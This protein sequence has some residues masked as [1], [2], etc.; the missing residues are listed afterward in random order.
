[1]AKDDDIFDEKLGDGEDFLDLDMSDLSIDDVSKKP[2]TGKSDGDIIDLIEL[3]EKGDASEEKGEEDLLQ[4][5]EDDEFKLEEDVSQEPK[6]DTADDAAAKKMRRLAKTIPDADFPGGDTDENE[7]EGITTTLTDIDLSEIIDD[8]DLSFEEDDEVEE[9][10]DENAISLE[11][12][13]KTLEDMPAPKMPPPKPRESTQELSVGGDQGEPLEVDLIQPED[14]IVQEE[15]SVEDMEKIIEE[16][17]IEGIDFELDTSPEEDDSSIEPFG[18]L[19]MEESVKGIDLDFESSEGIE[20]IDS[21]LVEETVPTTLEVPEELLVPEPEPEPVLE[22]AVAAPIG[23]S[24]EKA[25]EII[26]RV[27]QDTVERVAKETISELFAQDTIERIARESMKEAAEKV[28][29]EAI[30][31]LKQSLETVKE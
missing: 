27:V 20:E 2:V 24:E 13:D 30:D 17:S 19:E 15:I 14:E 29:S 22:Q 7:T 9:E 21:D 11:D 1:M 3:V 6:T 12:F 5:L 23:I 10:I 25:E 16:E 26:S 28:I 31:A 18:D 4:L 8:Q